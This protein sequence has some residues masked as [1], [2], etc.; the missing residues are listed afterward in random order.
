[1]VLLLIVLISVTIRPYIEYQLYAATTPRQVEARGSLA[2]YE[3]SAIEV[4]ERVSPSV[5]HIVGRGGG[6]EPSRAAPLRWPRRGR[7][8]PARGAAGGAEPPTTP[9]VGG[10]RAGLVFRPPRGPPAKA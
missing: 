8:G 7:R 6:N 3:K 9:G 1:M 4:F 5:V 2:D 10:A